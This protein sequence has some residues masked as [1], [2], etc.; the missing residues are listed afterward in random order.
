MAIEIKAMQPTD[1][2]CWDS[3]VARNRMS[4]PYHLSGW[5]RVIEESYGHSSHF[6]LAR[7]NRRLVGILPLVHMK[8]LLSG[9]SLISLPFLDMAGVLADNDVIASCLI[10]EA[11]NLMHRVRADAVELRQG[12]SFGTAQ[13]RPES[14]QNL[15]SRCSSSGDRVRMVIELPDHSD[16]LMQ[17]FRSKLRSQ[18][19]KSIQSGLETRVGGVEFL[20]DFYRVFTINMRDLGSPVH[21]KIFLQNILE[22]F[23]T[24]SRIFV[25]Y[26]GGEP[27]A[28]SIICTLNQTVYNP[29]ASS[30]RKYQLFNPNMLLY[31]TMLEYGCNHGF[32]RFDFGRSM[33]GSGPYRFKQQWGAHPVRLCW[34]NFPNL[35]LHRPISAANADQPMFNVAVQL[36]KR[37]PVPISR[38][39][40]PAIRK[41]IGL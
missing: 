9:N 14:K 15:I 17:S 41:H 40:G 10:H 32:S 21:S 34:V 33:E 29:W 25:V 11:L 5:Q 30:L 3:Y 4:T 8:H 23:P 39:L 36:W 12:G 26:K 31:W 6:L 24:H 1:I 13:I 22:L 28:G 7:K 38:M 27:V 19:K 2:L 37:M 16:L 20:D 35:S 18:V